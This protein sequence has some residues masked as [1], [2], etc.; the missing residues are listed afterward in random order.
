MKHIY[1]NNPKIIANNIFD[2]WE[3]ISTQRITL[4]TS[5]IQGRLFNNKYLKSAFNRGVQ[6]GARGVRLPLNNKE[7]VIESVETTPVVTLEEDGTLTNPTYYK[8][9]ENS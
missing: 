5:A 9:D 8:E 1:L 3:L 4:K 7:N 6:G 2:N